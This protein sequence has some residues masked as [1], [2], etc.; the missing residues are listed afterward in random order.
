MRII[1]SPIVAVLIALALV[2]QPGV[3][4]ACAMPVPGADPEQSMV[5]E[6]GRAAPQ[7]ARGAEDRPVEKVDPARAV[8][9]VKLV[10]LGFTDE[11]A[12][13]A[14]AEL[15]GADIAVLL[16]N[17]RMMQ[18]AGDLSNTGAAYLIGTLIV[19]GIVILAANGSGFVVTN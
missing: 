19:V 7:A 3:V 1:Q 14:A 9:A 12:Q 13:Q 8:I 16:E 6:R 15:T 11:E 4:M 5:T 17:D 18:R 2:A 10:E